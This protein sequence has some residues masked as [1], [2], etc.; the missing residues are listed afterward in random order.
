M[1]NNR[2]ADVFAQKKGTTPHQIMT[3]RQREAK[4]LED[5]TG[6][7]QKKKIQGIHDW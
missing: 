7:K 3:K 4:R 1:A 2:K 6:I 5:I